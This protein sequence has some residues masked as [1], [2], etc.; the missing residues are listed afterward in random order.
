MKT[1]LTTTLMFSITYL[2]TKHTNTT[3]EQATKN[4]LL[5]LYLVNIFIF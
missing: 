3:I 5:S 1:L 4:R 2:I